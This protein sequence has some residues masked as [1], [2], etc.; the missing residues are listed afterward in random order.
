MFKL[1]DMERR[2]VKTIGSVETPGELPGAR[3]DF[4]E[5]KWA[6]MFQEFKNNATGETCQFDI[7]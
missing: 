4:S 5:L 6:P 3:K 1:S 2:M 7:D